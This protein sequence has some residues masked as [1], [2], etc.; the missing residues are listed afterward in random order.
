MLVTRR[1]IQWKPL[2]FF[3]LYT[4]ILAGIGTLLGMPSTDGLSLPPLSPPDWLFPIAWTILYSLMS[5]AA[6]LVAISDDIDRTSSLQL[7]L[8]QVVVNILWPLLFFR[9]E[10]RFVAF[11][12]LIVLILLVL[13]MARRFKDIS[14]TAYLLLLPYIVWL[15]FAGYLN[16]GIYLLNR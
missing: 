6:Y 14:K 11:L 13:R 15:F 16:L 1:T 7:Y 12:W 4:F 3:L 9:L 2:L 5:I 10:W 8:A